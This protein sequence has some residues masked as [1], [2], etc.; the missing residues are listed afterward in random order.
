MVLRLFLNGF[1]TGQVQCR[2]VWSGHCGAKMGQIDRIPG[3][4]RQFRIMDQKLFTY[5]SKAWSSWSPRRFFATMTPL[6]SNRK[7]IG[8]ELMP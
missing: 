3:K 8:M 7:F 1:R 2:P 6:G 4:G 5:L